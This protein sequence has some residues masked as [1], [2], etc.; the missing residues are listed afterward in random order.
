[1]APKL[2]K[3]HNAR[4]QADYFMVDMLAQQ[5]GMVSTREPT[6]NMSDQMLMYSPLEKVNYYCDSG[7]QS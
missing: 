7:F 6:A 2:I 3:I 5:L 1:M 4:H